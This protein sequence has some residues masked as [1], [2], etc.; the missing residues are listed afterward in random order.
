MITY[1]FSGFNPKE[2]FG[3][4]VSNFFKEDMKNSKSIAFIPG[5]FDSP[6]K[7]KRYYERK[8]NKSRYNIHYGRRYSKT[9]YI[10]RKI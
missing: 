6:D 4:E 3:K 10:P 1:I 8:T 2:H 9:K 5:N 7:A